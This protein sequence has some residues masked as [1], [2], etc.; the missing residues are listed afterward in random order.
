MPKKIL[1][2]NGHPD[3]ESFNFALADAYIKGVKQSDFT[4]Y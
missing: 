1:L 4:H 2:I 3:K